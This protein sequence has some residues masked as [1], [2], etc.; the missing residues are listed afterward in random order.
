MREAKPT[1]NVN[2]QVHFTDNELF[3]TIERL[4]DDGWVLRKD[5]GTYCLTKVGHHYSS[6][7]LRKMLSTQTIEHNL[8]FFHGNKG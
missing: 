7:S 5:E 1:K 3:E 8:R 4:L 2:K 6:K